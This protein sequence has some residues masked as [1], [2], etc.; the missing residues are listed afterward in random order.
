MVRY[1][2]SRNARV[3]AFLGGPGCQRLTF[4]KGAGDGVAKLD[5][6]EGFLEEGAA[7]EAAGDERRKSRVVAGEEHGDVDVGAVEALEEL[8]AGER[9]HHE[10]GYKEIDLGM[11]FD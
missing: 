11:V 8:K 9:L 1:Y 5:G 2:F 6:G 4:G 7:S 3:T 10:A